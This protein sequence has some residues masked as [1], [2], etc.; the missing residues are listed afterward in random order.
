VRRAGYDIVRHYPP[1]RVSPCKLVTVAIGERPVSFFI[2]HEHD[3]IQKHHLAGRFYEVEELSLIARQFPRGGVFL[4]VGSNIGNHAIYA[5][6]FLNASKIIAIEP[7]PEAY[8]VLH[9]N[10]ALNGFSERLEHHAVGL[11]DA[12][13]WAKGAS[14]RNNMGALSLTP[15][16]AG[17]F[18]LTTADD[19]LRDQ[20]VDFVKIDTERM[21][22]AVLRGM[23]SVLWRDRPPVF[24]EVDDVNA[25]EVTDFLDELN[26]DIVARHRRYATNEN[27]LAVARRS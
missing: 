23:R 11:S 20:K 14:V 19:L 12:A 10:A 21:E 26:Y 17:E 6:N 8:R 22:L 9:V 25:A 16:A 5:A 2:T 27:F 3:A 18:R 1:E 24:V 4:D 15:A 7:N 13:G